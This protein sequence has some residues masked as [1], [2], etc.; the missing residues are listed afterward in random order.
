[1]SAIDSMD[2]AV[3]MGCNCCGN[4]DASRFVK[5]EDGYVCKC[6]GQWFRY[7]TDAE[8]SRCSQG[9][10]NLSNYK[11]DD[12]RNIFQ[13]VI[14]DNPR[15]VSARWGLLLARFGIV[16]TKAFAKADA[17]PVYCFPEYDEIT[18]KR[19]SGEEEY[20]EMMN[21]IGTDEELIYFYTTKAREIDC[22]IE[23]IQQNKI[24][25]VND[26]FI[27][28]K[29]DAQTEK[30]PELSGKT[31]DFDF[32]KKIY[33]ELTSRGVNV[34]FAPM[35][36]GTEQR[37]D[38]FIWPN[39]VKSKKMLLIASKEEYIDSVWV[40]SEWRRWNGLGREKELYICV[41]KHENESPKAVLP[42]ELLQN[43]SQIYTLDTYDKLISEIAADDSRALEG[44][45]NGKIVYKGGREERIRFGLVEIG[46]D[47]F[48]GRT[49]IIRVSLPS[50]V[51][52]IGHS[53]FAGCTSLESLTVREGTRIIE[54]N[55]FYGC[56]KL[57]ELSLPVTV[58]AIGNRAFYGCNGII[59]LNIPQK[60]ESIGEG[61]FFGCGGLMSVTVPASVKSFGM[62]AL[63]RCKNLSAITVDEKNERY[64]SAGNC[65]IDTN[66]STLIAGCKSS[67]LPRDGS[68]KAIGESAFAG[69]DIRNAAIPE[70]VT[71]IGDSAFAGC[72]E[73]V[74]VSIPA[75]TAEI[76]GYAFSHCKNLIKITVD[77]GNPRF[78]AV[79]NCLINKKNKILVAG[80]ASSHIPDDGSVQI[81]G[82]QAFM[83]ADIKGI[84][85][86]GNIEIIENEAFRDCR[87][88]ESVALPSGIIS[89]GEDAFR[90]CEK[91]ATVRCIPSV[92]EKIRIAKGN[93]PLVAAK[94]GVSPSA[95]YGGYTPM[96]GNYGE[97]ASYGSRGA[98]A[99]TP[100]E[101]SAAAY[102][103]DGKTE[104]TA[105]DF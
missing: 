17:E 100:R 77:E 88:L 3:T 60:T 76:G 68:I 48:K 27:C 85:I 92:W 102:P 69:C 41:L 66:S 32:A 71:S 82:A 7:E 78:A 65:L 37:N 26:V 81:I 16:F 31:E 89:I 98:C 38:T 2:R 35:T 103:A 20:A 94:E 99:Y 63:G 84:I 80:T 56:E 52:V 64:K 53:A 57:H 95:S 67:V 19:F 47:A 87:G 23:K 24:S 61:A 29:T 75:S 55:A 6:C 12:A 50:T 21:L 96:R 70:G 10:E 5:R 44:Q 93:E 72:A 91:L 59:A 43:E 36:L 105:L 1:M 74:S 45:E 73:L 101:V 15:S 90:G 51:A 49:D 13:R 42:H 34:F 83:G 25:S 18:G 9:Y 4:R 33:S 46:A 54:D 11:F 58:S 62:G 79:D 8:K 28:V 30:H 97:P 104:N 39:L 22:A 40:K 86:P 14:I